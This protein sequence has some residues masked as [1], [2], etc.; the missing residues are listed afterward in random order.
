MIWERISQEDD[1]HVNRLLT[2][3]D[4]NLASI[5]FEM[6]THYWIVSTFIL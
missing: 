5:R 2:L 6:D 3:N 4:S 1:K